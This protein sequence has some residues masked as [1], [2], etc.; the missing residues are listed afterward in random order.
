MDN[1]AEDPIA[2]ALQPGETVRWRAQPAP[3]A[4]SPGHTRSLRA[5][6]ALGAIASGLGAA[7]TVYALA[8]ALRHSDY[9]EA[10]LLLMLVLMTLSLFAAC[11]RFATRDHSPGSE[12]DAL[13]H[14]AITSRRVIV[15][16]AGNPPVIRAL[17]N[18]ETLDFDCVPSA[19]GPGSILFRTKGDAPAAQQPFVFQNLPDTGAPIKILRD[20]RTRTA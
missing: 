8:A 16:I 9:F 13:T 20:F 12:E 2:R 17:T 15:A 3:P 10:P 19:D 7:L 6:G 5:L 11:V 1:A 14:Y 18:D 4:P